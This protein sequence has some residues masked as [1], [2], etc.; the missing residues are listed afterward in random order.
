MVLNSMASNVSPAV[1]GAGQRKRRRLGIG[2]ISPEP[3]DADAIRRRGRDSRGVRETSE[4]RSKVVR[5]RIDTWMR[6]KMA[7]DLVVVCR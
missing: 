7:E 6:A 1:R 5:T 3:V 4:T 2:T